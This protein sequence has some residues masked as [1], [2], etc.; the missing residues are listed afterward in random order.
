MA[1]SAHADGEGLNTGAADHVRQCE[2]CRH[3]AAEVKRDERLVREA[4]SM[5]ADPAFVAG[6]MEEVR[7]IAAA[8]RFPRL[9]PARSIRVR[10]HWA[11][12]TAVA[13]AAVLLVAVA[14][15]LFVGVRA[16][17]VKALCLDNARMIANATRVY[18]NDHGDHLPV[19]QRWEQSLR[20][21]VSSELVFYCPASADM[22]YG[23]PTNL[24]GQSLQAMAYPSAT[25]TLFDQGPTPGDF[26]PR[27]HGVGSVAFLDGHATVLPALPTGLGA[28]GSPEVRSAD[29]SSRS[30]GAVR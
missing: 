25:L 8:E 15:P 14:A 29:P 21:Y 9:V 24:S 30:T 23:F 3:W 19:A 13:A 6:V 11:E 20:P 22:L 1:L 26:A 27:H 5:E 7:R 17:A 10:F 18:A 2:A 28:S 4:I 16:N 12:M